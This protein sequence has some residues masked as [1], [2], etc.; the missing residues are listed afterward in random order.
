MR[1]LIA[2]VLLA[3][4]AG[5]YLLYAIFENLRTQRHDISISIT[6]PDVAPTTLSV[7][8]IGDIHLSGDRESLDAF[9]G[10]LLEVKNARPDLVAFVGDYIDHS[11]V[12]FIIDLIKGHDRHSRDAA[13]SAQRENII[14]ALKLVDPLPRVVVLGNHET[15][16]DAGQWLVAFDRLAVDVL[17]N[18]VD[19]IKIGA[20][21]ICIRGLG[22]S[23]TNRFRYIDFPSECDGLP[24]LTITHDPAGAFDNRMTGLVIS[25]HT[26][27]GQIRFPLIGPLWVPSKAPQSA[28]CGLYQD[29]KKMVFVTSGVGTSILP[30]RLG[31]PSQWDMLHLSWNP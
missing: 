30:V 1:L 31:A 2:I 23:H 15:L 8:V 9:R 21:F 20:D 5:A 6:D 14:N 27:C 13:L 18:S 19:V 7:A 3:G 10:L 22:D 29:S 25:G 24:K 26:H 17:E 28:H 12:T 4:A 11:I 16:S